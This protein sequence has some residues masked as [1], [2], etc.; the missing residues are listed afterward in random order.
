MVQICSTHEEA[1]A[2]SDLGIT[3]HI[4]SSDTDV[5]VLALRPFPALGE[6]SLIITGTG[7]NRRRIKLKRYMIR[8][9][10]IS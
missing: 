2:L 6:D 5:F 7:S 8:W 3:V 1:V 4:Y 9:A 10:L